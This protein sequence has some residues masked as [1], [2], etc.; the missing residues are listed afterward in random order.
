MNCSTKLHTPC[1]V[2][3]RFPEAT[4]FSLSD[5]QKHGPLPGLAHLSIAT[6]KHHGMRNT[7]VTLQSVSEPAAPCCRARCDASL[8]A[9]V[10]VWMQTLAKGK[11]TPI[12]S[13]AH[14]EVRSLDCAELPHAQSEHWLRACRS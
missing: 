10:Q 11:A 14:C 2:P 7:E 4:I 5:L 8:C 13:H 1:C 9:A 12:H 3:C 6:S